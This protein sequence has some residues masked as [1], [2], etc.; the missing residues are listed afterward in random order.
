[1]FSAGLLW[2]KD[3]AKPSNLQ[4]AGFIP[5]GAQRSEQSWALL[6]PACAASDSN[7][8][9]DLQDRASPLIF[10]AA[11]WELVADLAVQ[12]WLSSRCLYA[13]FTRLG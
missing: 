12:G 7:W 4:F 10:R 2:D 11:L 3:F 13:G 5:A 8:G 9:R 1:M 6:S